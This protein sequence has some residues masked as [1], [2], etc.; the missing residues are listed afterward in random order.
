MFLTALLFVSPRSCSLSWAS[1]A[2]SSASPAAGWSSRPASH[3]DVTAP[4]ATETADAGRRSR[5]PRSSPTAALAHEP[6]LTHAGDARVRRRATCRRPSTT[7]SVASRT[8]PPSSGSPPHHDRVEPPS[9]RRPGGGGTACPP[10]PPGPGQQYAL[11]GRPRRVHRLQGVRGRLPQ[12]QRPRRGRDLAVGRDRSAASDGSSRDRSAAAP[13][14]RACHHCVDPACLNGCPAD[15][16]EKD[17][18]TGIV[19]HLDDQCIGCSYC[20]LTCPYE[21]PV[22]NADL[23]IVRK[24]DMCTDR[25]AEGEAPACVQGCPTEAITIDVVDVDDLVRRAR[26]R[27][28]T[29]SLVPGRPGLDADRA[30]HPLP[31]RPSRCRPTLRRRRP[32]LGR[33]RRTATPRSP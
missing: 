19:R 22:F 14:P 32:L 33:T 9:Q 8:S 31:C 21:V 26:R 20:T 15:A 16:Y 29:Q 5:S 2:W 24:C 12:P 27:T 7:S 3:A 23:G 28:S 25:L 11:R 18:V 13:S 1:P 6:S 4:A 30:H 10:P 17:P